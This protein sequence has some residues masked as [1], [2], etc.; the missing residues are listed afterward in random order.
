[1]EK[2]IVE[3]FWAIQK[4][5]VEVKKFLVLIGEQA[6]GKSTIAKLIY[7]FKSLQEDLLI[8]IFNNGTTTHLYPSQ[9]LYIP[10]RE[11]FY[12]FFGSTFHLPNFFIKYYYNVQKDKYIELSSEENT[13]ELK[14]IFSK[15]FNLLN[16]FAKQISSIRK[17]IQS[18]STKPQNI[19]EQ[20]VQEQNKVKIAKELSS[21]LQEMFES[22]QTDTLY[23]IA[24]RNATV[25]YSDLFEKYFFANVQQRLIENAKSAFESKL[26]TTD[27]TLMLKFMERV[28]KL[29]DFFKRFGGFKELLEANSTNENHNLYTLVEENIS[30]IL[31]GKYAVDNFGE[32]IV[33]NEKKSNYVYLSN[34]SSGQQESIRILQDLCLLILENSSFLRVFEEPEAHL[35]PMAQKHMI[36]L[37]ALVGNQNEHNQ[38]IIT[39]HSPYVLSVFNNLLFAKRAADKNP[40]IKNE[41]VEVIPSEY[42]VDAQ[43]VSVYALGK[44]ENGNYCTSILDNKTGLISQNYLDTISEE[45]GSEFEYIYSLHAKSFAKI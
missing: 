44:N 17:K 16:N 33:F 40:D 3:N 39:T 14:I 5:E 12:N 4:A 6:S 29:K 35:F 9:D 23:T 22:Q 1:M 31:K 45:L 24:G 37:L 20:L 18:Y 2:I 28:S 10:I 42:W 30:K 25:G 21:I 36:E 7:F 32:K 15:G 38:I 8:S 34:A 11:K 43:S 13:K 27:E 26:N 19:S 41:I